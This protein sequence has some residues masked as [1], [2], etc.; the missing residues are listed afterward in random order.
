MSLIYFN[1]NWIKIF[2]IN[3]I[4]GKVLRSV[5]V[6]ISKFITGFQFILLIWNSFHFVL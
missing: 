3:N 2:Y 6:Y 1:I 4:I 5:Y